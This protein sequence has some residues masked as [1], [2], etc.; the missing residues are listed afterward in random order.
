M[1]KH[2]GLAAAG[3]SAAG[4]SKKTIPARLLEALWAETGRTFGLEERS[5]RAAG[6]ICLA[7]ALTSVSL[8]GVAEVPVPL[9]MA[10]PVIGLTL[11]LPLAMALWLSAVPPRYGRL[12]TQVAAIALVAFGSIAFSRATA[13]QV[14]LANFLPA[15]LLLRA[16][17][18]LKR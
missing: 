9:K 17:D 3:I 13:V 5:A 15:L 8:F 11:A 1:A 4:T 16:G 18:D 2:S 12:A 6:I 10:A 14:S 7:L